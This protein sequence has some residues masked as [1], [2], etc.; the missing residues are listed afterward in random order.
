[1]VTLRRL[2]IAF[3]FL[4]AP[5]RAAA[6]EAVRAA[7]YDSYWLWAGVKARPEVDKARTIYL[8]QGEIGPDR[9]GAIRLKAQGGGQPGPHMATLWLA[10]RVRSLDWSPDIVAAIVR[11]YESWRAKPGPLAGVQIDFDAST[12]GLANYAAFLRNLRK[13]LPEGCALS[14]TG[15]MDWASQAAVEDIDALAGTVDEIIFQ[16]YRGRETVQNIDAYVARLDRLRIPFR[17]G[18]AEGAEWAP[19]DHLAQN[20]NF[21][22]YVVFLRN[23]FHADQ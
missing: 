10:Y 9:S 19:S 22:G 7:D 13:A 20:A 3:V 1:L 4:S 2:F 14:V 6:A 21:R 15:L 23:P 16:T 18:L 11:R 12:R 17:L 8:L 5:I